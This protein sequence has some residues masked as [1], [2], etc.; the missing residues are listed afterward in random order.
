MQT[1]YLL[2]IIFIAVFI[3]I[4]YDMYDYSCLFNDCGYEGDSEYPI[5]KK[6]KLQ[7]IQQQP[8]AIHPDNN[9]SKVY[10]YND[11]EF[12]DNDGF[13][14]E[15]MFKPK[16]N[17]LE[18]DDDNIPLTNDIPLNSPS[19]ELSSDLPI[20]NININYLLDKKTSKLV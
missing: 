15:L 20:A 5:K 1:V 14:N 16:P 8:A 4:I 3:Y 2:Q 17:K 9:V 6:A 7:P 18:F 10:T 13:V 12:I 11:N 19:C